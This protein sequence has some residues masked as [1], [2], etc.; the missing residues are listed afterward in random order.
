MLDFKC[1]KCGETMGV[2]SSLAG[3]REAC[4]SC[5]VEVAVPA[6]QETLLVPLEQSQPQPT[7][8]EALHPVGSAPPTRPFKKCRRCGQ[9][10]IPRRRRCPQCRA[11]TGPLFLWIFP[12]ILAILAAVSFVAGLIGGI[13]T[14]ELSQAM[15]V[16][17][18]VLLLSTGTAAGLWFGRAGAWYLWTFLLGAALFGATVSM[19]AS[20]TDIHSDVE[21]PGG[22]MALYF[23]SS[24]AYVAISWR[25]ARRTVWWWVT[26]GYML[27]IVLLSVSVM[28]TYHGVPCWGAMIGSTVLWMIVAVL[29]CLTFSVS[30]RWWCH[31]RLGWTG[32]YIEETV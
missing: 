24:L 9:A 28:L 22:R 11:L 7:P 16:M 3:K 17:V 23:F 13:E 4:P 1:P 26:A 18:P 29:V 12:P 21:P 8:S 10:L 5:G 6:V 30:V 32:K 14:N 19:I 20:A 25:T 31:V 27:M 2:P 15:T